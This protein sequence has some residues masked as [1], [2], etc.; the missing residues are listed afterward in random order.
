VDIKDV[1]FGGSILQWQERISLHDGRYMH[2][3]EADK[4]MRLYIQLSCI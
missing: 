3:L 4:L 2:A 1:G